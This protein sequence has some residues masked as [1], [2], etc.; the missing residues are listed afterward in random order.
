MCHLWLE[1][2]VESWFLWQDTPF[3]KNTIT[4]SH[5]LLMQCTGNTLKYWSTAGVFPTY[6]IIQ[7][8][9]SEGQLLLKK[10]VKK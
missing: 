4:D 8:L 9:V 1:E 3:F 6:P 5:V 2:N 10:E 7:G